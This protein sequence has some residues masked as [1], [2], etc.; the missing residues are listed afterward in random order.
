MPENTITEE[1]IKKKQIFEFIPYRVLNFCFSSDFI[2]NTSLFA[3]D[4]FE[5][6]SY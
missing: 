3:N 6:S 1:K 5:L 2:F 4:S